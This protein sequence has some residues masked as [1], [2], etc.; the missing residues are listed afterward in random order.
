MR[1]AFAPVKGSAPGLLTDTQ[2]PGGEQDAMSHVFAGALGLYR[3]STAHR[4]VPTEP[5]QAAEVLVFA[6]QFLRIV[7]RLKPQ[8]AGGQNL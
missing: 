5:A 8:P 6:S 1:A 2:L 4:Y 3:N 7:D